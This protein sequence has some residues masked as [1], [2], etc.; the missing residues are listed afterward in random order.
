MSHLR[1]VLLGAPGSGKGTQ[2]KKISR[3]YGIPQI[4]TGDILRE[5][6]KNETALG[7]KAKPYMDSGAL[8]PD[9][10]MVSMVAERLLEGDCSDGFVLDGFPRTTAQADALSTMLRR[11]GK[12]LSRVINID[13]DEEELVRRLSGRRVCRSCG[14]G[15]HVVFNV[16]RQEGLCDKCSGE[17]YQRQDDKPETVRARLKVYQE[18]TDPLIG[19]Y[20]S[21]GLL[22]TVCGVGQIDEIFYNFKKVL[23]EIGK[24]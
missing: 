9:S 24:R 6:V 4:S 16:P 20:K 15:Y 12:P 8:V 13:V 5:S 19:Y 18:Q 11:T 1:L 17:L 7:L 2:A 10:L 22:S 23:D 14:E 21:K 3:F